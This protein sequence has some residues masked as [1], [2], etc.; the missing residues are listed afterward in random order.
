MLVRGLRVADTVVLDAISR[1][2]DVASLLRIVKESRY[3]RRSGDVVA[4]PA[5]ESFVVKAAQKAWI[6]GDG[7]PLPPFSKGGAS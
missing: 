4:K 2:L 3:R 5:L 6:L 7:L 1:G